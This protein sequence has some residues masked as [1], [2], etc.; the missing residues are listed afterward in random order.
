MTA[1]FSV[2]IDLGT[3]NSVVAYAPLPESKSTTEPQV[4]LLPIPQLIG[5]DQIESRS[6][7]PSFLYLPRDS[8]LDSLRFPLVEDP[9]AG[10]AGHYARAQAAEN[11]QRVVVAAKSWLCHGRVGR[12]EAVLP[13]QSPTEIPKVSALDCSRRYL[14]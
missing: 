11:P 1:R 5:P 6:S 3:T 7:L 4:E 10:I 14:M 12:T 9:Q 13:W 2:G 8:E